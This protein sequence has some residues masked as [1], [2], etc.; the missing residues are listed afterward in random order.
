MYFEQNF[1]EI[2]KRRRNNLARAFKVIKFIGLSNANE[3]R[4]ICANVFL[5][6]IDNS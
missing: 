2:L 4:R 5:L 1:T 3:F 6:S